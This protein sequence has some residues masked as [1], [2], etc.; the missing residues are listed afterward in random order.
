MFTNTFPQN[1]KTQLN[2]R[3]KF[4]GLQ[5]PQEQ[6][7]DEELKKYE[8]WQSRT[9][10]VLAYSN[11][12]YTQ[13]A[14]LN[15]DN[16]DLRWSVVGTL[17]VTD[18]AIRNK[19]YPSDYYEFDPNFLQNYGL[20][21]KPVIKSFQLGAKGDIGTL[22]DVTLTIQCYNYLQFINIK[23]YFGVPCS[24]IFIQYGNFVSQE[25]ISKIYPPILDSIQ[26]LKGNSGTGTYI[27]NPTV[28]DN[29]SNIVNIQYVSGVVYGF[30]V[31][32]NGN[33]FTLIVKMMTKGLSQI[34]NY[35]NFNEL[36]QKV[37]LKKNLIDK[38]NKQWIPQKK[39]KSFYNNQDIIII[40]KQKYVTFSWIAH[41]ILSY[42]RQQLYK[43]GKN[44]QKNSLQANKYVYVFKPQYN[45]TAQLVSN[46]KDVLLIND[47]KFNSKVK[48]RKF[49]TTFDDIKQLQNV[50][51]EKGIFQSNKDNNI[52]DIVKHY[53]YYQANSKDYSDKIGWLGNVYI[54]LN[55]L[56]DIINKEDNYSINDLLIQ[57]QNLIGNAFDNNLIIAHSFN[58]QRQIYQIEQISLN[59]A[60]NPGIYKIPNWGQKSIVKELNYTIR[61]PDTYQATIYQAYGQNAGVA[62]NL[63]KAIFGNYEVF[64]TDIM[65]INQN[66]KTEVNQSANP[67]QKVIDYKKQQKQYGDKVSKIFDTKTGIASNSELEK[68]QTIKNINTYNKAEVEVIKQQLLDKANVNIL[69]SQYMIELQLTLDFISNIWF[70]HTFK[71]EF[72]PLGW[73]T[74]FYVQ[75][76]KQ[77]V[78]ENGASTT[79]KG[80]MI[81]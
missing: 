48:G 31:E 26:E 70:G 77:R 12:R 8:D 1:V 27:D 35:A 45:F 80:R 19:I 37:N 30:D 71:L 34:F 13:S 42:I 76:V 47:K 4:N 16:Y 10:F 25:Q 5:H 3:S 63:F 81:G 78:D 7:T 20:V 74:R 23:R 2:L 28:F 66:L 36:G 33:I 53:N 21:P 24:S 65:L 51:K 54:R 14:A 9:P 39:N 67:E 50:Y 52:T 59:I 18:S 11:I 49:I 38:I 69:T 79:I 75:Q 60:Y 15:N 68:Q 22:R 61:M 55:K 62:N 73:D 57:L 32:Q 46:T 17:T 6:L 40:N 44:S 43:D 29:Y 41:F 64:P 56:I 58:S 72:N